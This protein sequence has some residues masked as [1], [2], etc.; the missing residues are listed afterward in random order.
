MSLIYH[1]D[2]VDAICEYLEDHSFEVEQALTSMHPGVDII[3]ARDESEET[4]IYV[5]VKGETSSKESSSTL[6]KAFNNAQT[7][8]HVADALYKAAKMLGDDDLADDRRVAVALPKTEL[9]HK[10]ENPIDH[11]FRNLGVG[12]FWVDRERNVKLDAPWELE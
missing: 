1:Q 2:V 4:K 3:A 11:A 5:E 9:H 10:F 7:K 8:D 6:G 12:V